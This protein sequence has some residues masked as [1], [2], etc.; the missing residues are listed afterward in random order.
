[1]EREAGG[2]I[3]M[4]NTC[5]P[6]TV[7]FQFMTKFTTNIK[8]KDRWGERPALETPLKEYLKGVLVEACAIASPREPD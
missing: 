2:G 5:K 6:M 8:K 1:M 7:S 3:G 4:G